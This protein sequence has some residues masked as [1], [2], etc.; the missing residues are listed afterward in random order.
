MTTRS[1][2][3][4]DDQLGNSEQET[5]F[6]KVH[7]IQ[8]AKGTVIFQFT[9][10]RFWS[11][12]ESHFTLSDSFHS[13]CGRLLWNLVVLVQTVFLAAC[14]KFVLLMLMLMHHT[15][16]LYQTLLFVSNL[17]YTAQSWMGTQRQEYIKI[18]SLYAPISHKCWM[19][20]VLMKSQ[21]F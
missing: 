14:F 11:I 6:L 21:S 2:Y 10:Q 9:Q 5:S 16:K 18:Q 3:H 4:R 8:E 19:L 13:F 20:S 7:K 17:S 12:G 1:P 15:I